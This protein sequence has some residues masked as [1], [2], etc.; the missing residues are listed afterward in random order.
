MV[1]NP[2][3]L[4]ARDKMLLSNLTSLPA[5]PVQKFWKLTIR[6]LTDRQWNKAPHSIWKKVDINRH[7]NTIKPDIEI[8][9]TRSNTTLDRLNELSDKTFDVIYT[10]F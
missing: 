3:I 5:F 8:T 6:L 9:N 2:R 7:N 1:S 10:I 4:V